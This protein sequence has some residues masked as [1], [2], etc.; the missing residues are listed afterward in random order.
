MI[1][2]ITGLPGNGKT[3]YTLW[4]VKER[5]ERE[6]RQV[7][8]SGIPELKIPE[9]Q[10]VEDAEKWHELPVGSII[11]IDEAQRIFRPRGRA[12]EPPPHIALLETHRHSGYDIYIITQHPSLID[13]SVRRLA[14]THRHVQRTFGASR[15]VIHEWGEVHLDCERKRNDSS[16][17][18]WKYP[19][20]VYSL[21]KSAE[22]HTHKLQLPKHVWYLLICIVVFLGLAIFIKYRVGQRLD[23]S[24]SV[25]SKPTPETSHQPGQFLQT[26]L[27]P[28]EKEPMT[29]QQ[30]IESMMPRVPGLQHT[31]SRYDELTKPV[32][33][34]TIAGCVAIGKRCQCYTGQGTRYAAS[35]AICRSIVGGNTPFYDFVPVQAAATGMAAQRTGDAVPVAAVELRYTEN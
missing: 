30:F 32:T 6:K 33:V 24:Q 3:L 8:Y 28:N 13:N 1:Y 15:A 16:K 26:G 20:G 22:V 18:V 12:G 9:W 11:V 10:E 35:D 4:H 34:P 17:T 29:A 14:G 25:A 27:K 2:L 7:F 19:K 21:Y 31:A 5:A 23:P